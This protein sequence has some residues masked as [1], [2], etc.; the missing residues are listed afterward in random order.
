MLCGCHQRAV[1]RKVDVA[2]TPKTVFIVA[3]QLIKRVIAAAVRITG[4]A[5]GLYEFATHRA[6]AGRA[7][8]RTDLRQRSDGLLVQEVDDG[9]SGKGIGSHGCSFMT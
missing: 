2:I 7:E 9:F 8:C 1:A 5:A 3:G 4:S 6:M